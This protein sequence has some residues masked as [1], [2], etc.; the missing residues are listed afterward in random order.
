MAMTNGGS[1]SA[2]PGS[3][4]ESYGFGQ[5]TDSSQLE[6]FITIGIKIYY[7]NNTNKQSPQNTVER[8]KQDFKKGLAGG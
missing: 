7:N 2:D 5:V 8:Y 1:A 3:R 4:P 6:P